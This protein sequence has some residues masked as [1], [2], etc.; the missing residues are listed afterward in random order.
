M[1]VS[2]KGKMFSLICYSSLI[3]TCQRDQTQEHF[4][5]K[6][7]G[8]GHFAFSTFLGSPQLTPTVAIQVLKSFP[9]T[10]ALKGAAA[11]CVS[12]HCLS[13]QCS[14]PC[15]IK[16]IPLNY[17]EEYTLTPEITANQVKP[18]S[19]YTGSSQYWK[20]LFIPI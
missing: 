7:R 4:S 8:G 14:P 6:E 18:I 13:L 5:G 1:E 11:T 15:K 3:L 12:L 20:R 16:L 9:P 17:M 2:R 10:L 19:N